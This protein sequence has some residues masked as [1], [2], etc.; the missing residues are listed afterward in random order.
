MKNTT[1]NLPRN[2]QALVPL[3]DTQSPKVQDAF[4]FLLATATHEAGKFELL[5]QVPL[6][7]KATCVNC[8]GGFLGCFLSLLERDAK[9]STIRLGGTCSHKQLLHPHRTL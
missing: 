2:L 3:L 1:N 7:R 4:Q 8:T 5:H 6:K 9:S